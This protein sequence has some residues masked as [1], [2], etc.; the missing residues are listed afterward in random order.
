MLKDF[1]ADS[2]AE[3]E[4]LSQ[5]DRLGCHFFSERSLNEKWTLEDAKK[6]RMKTAKTTH[7]VNGEPVEEPVG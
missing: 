3:R 5:T 7:Y 2:D 4:E 1:E 6:F